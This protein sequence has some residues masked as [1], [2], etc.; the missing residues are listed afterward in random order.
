MAETLEADAQD[1]S[2][3]EMPVEAQSKT[4]HGIM[5]LFKIGMVALAA[6]LTFFVMWLCA[7]AGWFPSLVVG[8]IIAVLGGVFYAGRSGH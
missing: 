2:R 3:G 4:F 1:Y 7:H 8:I 6:L 5:R